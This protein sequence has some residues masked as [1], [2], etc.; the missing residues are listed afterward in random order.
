[1]KASL[2]KSLEGERFSVEKTD[3]ILPAGNYKIVS[4]KPNFSRGSKEFST[5]TVK[6]VESGKIYHI[7]KG[8]TQMLYGAGIS[9]EAEGDVPC[10]YCKHKIPFDTKK[11]PYSYDL[12]HSHMVGHINSMHPKHKT[13]NEA[14]EFTHTGKHTEIHDALAKKKGVTNPWALANWI[15]HKNKLEEADKS[16]EG[17][18]QCDEEGCGWKGDA[19]GATAHRKA[20]GHQ[21]MGFS[22]FISMP[23]EKPPFKSKEDDRFIDD[24]TMMSAVKRGFNVRNLP[25]G[26]HEMDKPAKLKHLTS[27]G[28]LTGKEAYNAYYGSKED[29]AG[30]FGKTKPYWCKTCGMGAMKIDTIKKHMTE[31]GHTGK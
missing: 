30:D 17:A 4:D 1:M 14:K 26:W 2:A 12:A 18:W 31:T 24:K 11:D 7:P 22:T 19:P 23:P 20:T 6:S 25:T 8:N 5:L 15:V 29:H 10:P 27:K 16:I 28:Y 3:M 9:K 13:Y 21:N